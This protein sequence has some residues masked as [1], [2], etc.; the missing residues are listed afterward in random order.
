[1]LLLW[2]AFPVSFGI[3]SWP[4]TFIPKYMALDIGF[5]SVSDYVCRGIVS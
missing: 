4:I 1:M 3:V 2:E 5:M